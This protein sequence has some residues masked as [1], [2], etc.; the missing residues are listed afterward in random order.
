MTAAVAE[1]SPPLSTMDVPDVEYIVPPPGAEYDLNISSSP[2]AFKNHKQ[3]PHPRQGS[4]STSGSFGFS[5][6]KRSSSG[7]QSIHT[8]R[9]QRRQIS[10]GELPP[11]PP[12]HSR[13][14][15]S[16]KSISISNITPFQTPAQS[17]EDVQD[18][19]SPSTPPNQRSPPTPEV[20]PPRPNARSNVIS[21][22]PALTHRIPSK[23]TTTDSRTESFR[24]ALESPE[25]SEAEDE[26]GGEEEEEEEEDSNPTLRPAQASSRTSQITVHGLNGAESKV[27]N[28]IGL[29]T[30]AES[31]YEDDPHEL[32]P[33]ATGEFNSFDGVWGHVDSE[34]EVEQEW[35]DNLSR[36]VTVKKRRHRSPFV[37]GQGLDIVDNKTVSPTN[38]T[39][40]IRG[41]PLQGRILTYHSPETARNFTA[42]EVTTAETT[43]RIDARR[44]S[45]M[46]SKSAASTIV[47]AILVEAPPA[48]RNRTLRHVKRVDA[49]RDSVWQSPLN[50]APGIESP[51]VPRRVTQANEAIR[52]SYASNSTV[53]SISSRKARREVWKSGAIPVVVVPD[54]HSST[55]SSSQD[56]SLRSVSSQ[57]SKRS[58]SIGSV[59]LSQVPKTQDLSPYFDRPP[60]RN[61]RTSESDGSAAGDQRTIDFPPIVPRRSSSL[62]A[63]TSR[64]G[65]RRASINKSHAGSLTA[66]SLQA[67][68]DSVVANDAVRT[69]GHATAHA[70]STR[71]DTSLPEVTVSSAPSYFQLKSNES[72]PEADSHKH[73]TFDSQLGSP[74]LPTQTTPFS[75]VSV[76]TSGTAAEISQAMA[77]S[78]DRHQNR[79]VLMIDHRPSE[80]SDG[81]IRN[82]VPGKP[83]RPSVSIAE[84]NA[85]IIT[86]TECASADEEPITPPQKQHSFL[87]DVESPLRNPRVPPEPPVLQFIPATPS[88]LTPADER[89]RLLGNF[90]DAVEEDE[91]P[92]RG[93]AVVRQALSKRR[94]SYGPSPS[95]E[96]P[97]FLTRTLSLSRNIRKENANGPGSDEDGDAIFDE[98]PRDE[99]RLHPDWRPSYYSDFYEDAGDGVYDM[100]G[101][102]EGA[103]WR[104]PPVDNRP[105]PPKRSLSDRMKHTFAIMPVRNYHDEY[106][107]DNE[108]ERRTIRRDHSGTLRVVKHRGSVGSLRGK[109]RRPETAP[110]PQRTPIFPRKYSL[111]KLRRRGSEDSETESQRLGLRRTWSLTQGMQ[112]LSRRVS[113]KRREKRS[114][115]L[116][117]KI[118]APKDC[119][120]G[121]E[122]VIRSGGLR[123]DYRTSRRAGVEPEWM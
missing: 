25:P 21:E 62:S 91:K 10:G 87:N 7:S 106:I 18:H 45:A 12:A 97:G 83:D 69:A 20:T 78:I 113:E 55:R 75:Q 6:S 54:R 71:T 99:T 29:V 19:V 111:A 26:E 46:S 59:P 88:G 117:K 115:E 48:P 74:L 104:Y 112:G 86:T 24:T 38:A 15:S 89:P 122:K 82:Q 64:N 58:Q 63:P 42:P 93:L 33:K 51:R 96:R 61:R 118:S 109:K 41:L 85:P 80:S 110:E 34:V 68:N 79:S 95:R 81:E 56:R 67:H 14:S 76:E 60:R 8:L 30:D 13:T 94:N 17:S 1:P 11:T 52:E 102:E 27:Q 121:V 107:H 50:S 9:H 66:E 57:R 77:V 98:P 3:L 49:L 39:E 4:G 120:D 72:Q 40:A 73:R 105:K 116:R 65:S 70:P 44:N 103:E 37:N 23:S 36:N 5:E 101:D 123:E 31:K 100:G 16:S 92:V 90:Y 114:D 2:R 108:P 28:G 47:E 43:A 32:T 119:R 35:D 22:R 84:V 53:N